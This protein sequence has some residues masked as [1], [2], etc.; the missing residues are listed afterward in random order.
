MVIDGC[1]SVIHGRCVGQPV[2]D[3]MGARWLE[4]RDLTVIGDKVEVP[5]VGL[6]LGRVSDAVADNHRLVNVKLLGCYSIACMINV[7]AETS[8][9]DHVFMWN[10]QPDPQTYCLVQDGLNHF[11]AH[12]EFIK[13]RT[14]VDRDDSFNENEFINCD[15]RHAGGGIPIWLGDTARQRFYRCYAAGTG[16]AAFLIYS[17]SNGH[18]M[19]DIDCHCEI[20]APSNIFIFGSHANKT[21][22]VRGFSYTDHAADV[23][24]AVFTTQLPV[25][26]VILENAKLEIGWFPIQSCR[27]LDDPGRWSISGSYYNTFRKGWN[28]DTCFTGTA[29]FGGSISQFGHIDVGGMKAR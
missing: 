2:L 27:L 18:Q 13:T 14:A 10:D 25:E 15:F 28:A 24:D 9:F 6:Q 20:K 29:A 5:R 1:G 23:S 19:I 16:P 26:K 22:T 7:A 21:I 4:L 3:A 11:L 12:S 8:G 17:G